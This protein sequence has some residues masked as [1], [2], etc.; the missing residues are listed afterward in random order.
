MADQAVVRVSKALRMPELSKGD[1]LFEGFDT[2][3][4]YNIKTAIFGALID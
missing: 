2:G 4:Q 3:E 1:R